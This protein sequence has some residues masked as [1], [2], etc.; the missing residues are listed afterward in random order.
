MFNSEM[1]ESCHQVTYRQTH[2]RTQP[3]IVKDWR[4]P[5][6]TNKFWKVHL[7]NISTQPIFQQTLL[8]SHRLKKIFLLLKEEAHNDDD[9]PGR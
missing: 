4:R 6:D 1:M 9:D 8:W 7:A 2:T 5:E 3:F